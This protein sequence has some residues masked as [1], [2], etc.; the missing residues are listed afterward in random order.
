MVTKETWLEDND[1]G[2]RLWSGNTG[3]NLVCDEFMSQ[4]SHERD[5]QR[6]ADMYRNREIECHLQ[7]T[8]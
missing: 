2:E 6:Q 1:Q 5:E 4:V 8:L 3:S 7:R